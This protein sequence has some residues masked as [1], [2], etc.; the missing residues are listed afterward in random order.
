MPACRCR[1]SLALALLFAPAWLLSSTAQAADAGALQLTLPKVLHAVVGLPV[2]VYFDNV[3]LTAKP[4]SYRFEV[5]CDVGATEPQRWVATPQAAGRFDWQ[6]RIRDAEGTIVEQGQMTL[7]VAPAA[8]GAGR[9]L[10]LLIV[11]DSLTHASRYPNEIAHLLSEPGNPKWQMIG[12][13]RPASAQ[14]GVAHEGYGG[15][16]WTDFLSRHDPKSAGDAAG[17]LARRST[18]PF[19]FADEQG[20]M[21]LN[22]PRY[23]SENADGRPPAV[24]TFLLGINDCFGANPEDPAAMLARIDAVLDQA[25][26]LLAAFHAAAPDALLAVGLTTPPNARESGFEANYKGRYQRWGWKRIQHRLVQR[27]IERLSQRE[28]ENIH[29]VATQLG[30]DPVAGYPVDNGVHPNAH[31]YSQ[32]GRSLYAW[33]KN[34]LADAPQ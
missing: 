10:R 18:S 31:G 12:T 20:H 33:L 32:I 34:A 21:T 23:F 9:E 16:K 30:L 27:M 7:Q 6:V 28:K 5:E 29:L 19:L 1:F 15:W 17:P 2:E 13:H 8:A 25:D 26:Q 22:L 14:P 11:G 4:E 3:V 24:V